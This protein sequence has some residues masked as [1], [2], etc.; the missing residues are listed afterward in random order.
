MICLG[1]S[2]S[3]R[4]SW[5]VVTRGESVPREPLPGEY[6]LW[7]LLQSCLSEPFQISD[8]R[9]EGLPVGIGSPRTFSHRSFGGETA[10]DQQ[11][12]ED[13][14]RAGETRYGTL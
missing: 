11:T 4:G 8:S 12:A 6:G 5:E 14:G 9:R 10:R 3:P 13:T 7:Y 2:Y 1:R